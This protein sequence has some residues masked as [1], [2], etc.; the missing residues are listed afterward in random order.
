MSLVTAVS[1]I[2]WLL[3]STTEKPDSCGWNFSR[4]PLLRSPPPLAEVCVPIGAQP[5]DASGSISRMPV[6]PIAFS[7]RIMI[8]TISWIGVIVQPTW[9]LPA[10]PPTSIPAK[11]Y[12]SMTCVALAASV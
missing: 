4:I 8:T 5:L 7:L 6:A 12:R 2:R 1:L 3:A 11:S 10:P 9:S